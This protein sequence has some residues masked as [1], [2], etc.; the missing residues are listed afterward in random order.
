MAVT[1]PTA[2]AN[3][4]PPNG[5]GSFHEMETLA[6]KVKATVPGVRVT[7]GDSGG[8]LLARVKQRQGASVAFG[9]DVDATTIT[10]AG[11]KRLP[12]RWGREQLPVI[13][14]LDASREEG[15]A[16]V[17]GA[18]FPGDDMAY[19]VR[20]S[21]ADADKD[22]SGARIRVPVATVLAEARARARRTK[23]E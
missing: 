5:S 22:A 9:L 14:Y 20:S 4:R 6:N 3:T 16:E 23:K 10:A 13:V 19:R 18:V 15:R 12:A 1:R 21:G 7:G 11:L 17:L 2:V 8:N